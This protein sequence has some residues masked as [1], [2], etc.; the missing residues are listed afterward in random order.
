MSPILDTL[1]R[2]ALSWD[3]KD[4]YDPNGRQRVRLNEQ[5]DLLE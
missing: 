3:K 5:G 2:T 1:G 4:E